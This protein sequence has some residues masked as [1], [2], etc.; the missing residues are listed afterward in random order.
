MYEPPNQDDN[1][2]TY[3]GASEG[4][5]G[6]FREELLQPR[7]ELPHDD[8]ELLRSDDDAGDDDAGDDAAEGNDVKETVDAAAAASKQQSSAVNNKKE[9][10]LPSKKKQKK[11]LG[12]TISDSSGTDLYSTD[13]ERP[14]DR[15]DKHSDKDAFN[16]S[17][18]PSEHCDQC[19]GKNKMPHMEFEL[20]ADGV[21]LHKHAV[22]CAAWPLMGQL[23]FIS[24]CIH[25]KDKVRF[26]MPRNSQPVIIGFFYGTTKPS[27]ANTYLKCVFKEMQLAE[28]RGLCTSFL[29]YYV[30][31]GPSRN[32]IKGFPS[33]ATSY[34]GCE[35]S[36]SPVIA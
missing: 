7:K 28:K 27:S 30:G 25:L 31:D 33:S 34:C 20:S 19:Q 11:V 3:E 21:Q 8:D 5:G 16:S 35:R 23:L 15:H 17:F 12:Y 9:S 13:E 2:M 29:R 1:Y 26:Y 6:A 14:T 10:K 32:F 24:P 22:K 18:K 4:E 36:V